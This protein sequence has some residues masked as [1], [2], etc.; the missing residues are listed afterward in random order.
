MGGRKD[1][2][3]LNCSMKSL[4]NQAQSLLSWRWLGARAGWLPQVWG[5]DVHSSVRHRQ[6]STRLINEIISKHCSI[7]KLFS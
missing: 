2:K 6:A 1:P 3:C 4:R 5:M 7:L